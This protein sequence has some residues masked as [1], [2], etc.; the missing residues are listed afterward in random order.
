MQRR[1]R[2]A[3]VKHYL[4]LKDVGQELEGLVEGGEARLGHWSL[5]MKVVSGWPTMVTQW[6]GLQWRP[7]RGEEKQGR[8]RA[9]GARE[10][11]G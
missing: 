7:W 4:G 5:S 11:G 6:A 9:V 1:R 8:T 10:R 2:E 3:S